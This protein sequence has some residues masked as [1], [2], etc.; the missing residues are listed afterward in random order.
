MIIDEIYLKDGELPIFDIIKE[1]GKYHSIQLDDD[2][3]EYE[4]A[5]SPPETTKIIM[6]FYLDPVIELKEFTV[7]GVNLA[8]D[9]YR[10]WINSKINKLKEAGCNYVCKVW[11]IIPRISLDDDGKYRLFCV[12]AFVGHEN[13]TNFELTNSITERLSKLKEYQKKGSANFTKEEMEDCKRI[14]SE[15][16]RS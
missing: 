2:G 7:E 8:Y 12:V 9:Q 16:K 6:G 5:K 10:E 15:L 11:R 3:N 13:R 1:N 14:M 4:T